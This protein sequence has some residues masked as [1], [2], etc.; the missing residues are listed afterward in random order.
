MTKSKDGLTAWEA[1]RLFSPEPEIA[2][3]DMIK[4]DLELWEGGTT[5][6]DAE[7][8][9][10][11]G[12]RLRPVPGVLVLVNRLADGTWYAMGL[13]KPFEPNDPSEY[14]PAHLWDI[15]DLDPDANTAFGG[16]LEYFLLL[17]HKGK[18]ERR[19]TTQAALPRA[20]TQKLWTQDRTDYWVNRATE[21]RRKSPRLFLHQ[22]AWKIEK[23]DAPDD[24]PDDKK[25]AWKKK[26]WTK[27]NIHRRLKGRL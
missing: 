22:I 17:F 12:E 7:Y 27:E 11:L 1:I 10:R 5:W 20:S 19:P 13:R 2:Q 18:Y 6:V 15:L 9:E 25:A 21:I 4:S 8:D 16:G 26:G 14:I 23:E 24:L 3:T